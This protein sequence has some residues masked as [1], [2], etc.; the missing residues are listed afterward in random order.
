MRADPEAR[1]RSIAAEAYVVPTATD[2]RERPESDGTITWDSTGVIVVRLQ[3]GGEEGL[4]FVHTSPAALAIVRELLCPV[5]A[6]MDARDTER[7][8]WTMARAV[9]N[10]GWP[11]LCASAISV[12]D[13]AV[14]DLA[15]RLAQ[16]SLTQYLGGAHDTVPAYGS[17][18]FT[19]YTDDEL[20]EQLGAWAAH[21]L[22][23]VKMKVG[24]H[25]EDDVRRVALA[26]EAVGPRTELFV[27]ANGAYARKQALDLAER[28]AE[29]DV[30]WFE[31]PVSSDDREG[32]HLL[33]DRMPAP[34]RVA[35]GEY[36]YV[37]TDFRDLLVDGC[38][39]VLQADATRCGITGFR[40]AAALAQAFGVPLS[41]HTAPALHASVG[42]AFDGVINVE[43]FHDHARI[44]GAFFDGVPA[45]RGGD[46]VPDRSA[47]GHGLTLREADAAPYRVDAFTAD[48]DD[49]GGKQ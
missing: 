21:G 29:S 11:G 9:R 35:A 47:P 39:D 42:A 14:H 46:L 1:L 44:A 5:L 37:P 19:D 4:G 40:A 20:V 33:R 7:I 6:G 18:G 26:R 23:A 27:D 25:P 15:A 16:V 36:G 3:A 30:T 22:S 13:I 10:A 38:V 45:L 49:G 24:S 17:G 41:A 34:I 31:E 48:L 12:V 8:F 2:G 28:F 32:L 43:Y